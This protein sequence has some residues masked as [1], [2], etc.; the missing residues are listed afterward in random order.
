MKLTSTNPAS[1]YKI[2][3]SVEISTTKEI[4]EKV[5]KANLS[6][7]AWRDIGVKGRVKLL[8]QLAKSF[9]ENRDNFAKLQ[10]NEMGM[11]I[12]ESLEDIDYAIE[13]F[14]S[15]LDSSTKYLKPITTKNN[16]SEHNY[17]VFEPYGVVACIAPWNYPFT[18]FV[19][20]CGQNL[21][22]GN[23]VI[24]KH[25]EETPLCGKLIEKIVSSKLPD[26]VF[27]EIYGDG[28]VGEY[29][30]NQDINFICF[31]GSTKTGIKINKIA[32]SRLIPTSLELGGSAPGI[33]C[34]D[35]D[36]K[37]IINTIYNSRFSNCGQACDALKRLIVHK[38]KYDEI[39]FELTDIIKNKK[40]GDPTNNRTDIGPLVSKRQLNI[41]EEQI[42]D[43]TLNGAKIIIG[44]NKPKNLD[45]SYFEPT[46][47]T[48]ITK[49]M[50]IWKEEVFGPILPIVIYDTEDQALKL[51]NDTKF[52][53]GAYVFTK[54]SKKF[55]QIANQLDSGMISQNKLSYVN[56]CN[57]FTGYKM[58]GGG[59]EHAQFGFN[60]VTQIK[61]IVKEK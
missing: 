6:K 13:Y 49:D 36:I 39:I 34:E 54:D 8:R 32:A 33:V 44:G 27:N 45:G 29:L 16:K 40:I 35:A 19:W 21:V 28:S 1:G 48:N 31:T 22:A 38:S 50:R 58:S 5:V 15:Y 47:I 12:N 61:V 56:I 3:G 17:V 46:L 30:I 42:N 41:L 25:S 57:P 24:F 7:K 2:I 55:T 53:L 4:N 10:S 59:H 37:S 20:Q 60:E 52:G 14:N 9:V 51:A 26:G 43:A 18:N 23:V 11:P